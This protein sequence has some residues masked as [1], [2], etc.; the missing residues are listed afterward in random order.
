MYITVLYRE[1]DRRRHSAW[2][3]GKVDLSFL[4]PVPDF[5]SFRSS[6][7]DKFWA[8]VYIVIVQVVGVQR[9]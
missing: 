5:R 8:L 1:T 3:P 7:V 6:D 9:N 4:I 2:L